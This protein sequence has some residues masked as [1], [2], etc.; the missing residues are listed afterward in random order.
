[1]TQEIGSRIDQW[2][3]ILGAG[4]QLLRHWSRT[5]L[6]PSQSKSC[7]STPCSRSSQWEIDVIHNLFARISIRIFKDVFSHRHIVR[8][9]NIEVPQFRL[10]GEFLLTEG[11]L[12]GCQ[13]CYRILKVDSP[14]FRRSQNFKNKKLKC[15]WDSVLSE[16]NTYSMLFG[17]KAGWHRQEQQDHGKRSPWAPHGEGTLWSLGFACSFRVLQTWYLSNLSYKHIF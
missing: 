8:A 17:C 13:R 16:W 10:W 15:A 12:N 6:L 11:C 9:G 5:S 2:H 7:P 14:F 1:M 3:R 4:W